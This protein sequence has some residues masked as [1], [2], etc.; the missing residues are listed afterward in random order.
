MEIEHLK[1]FHK[2]MDE[3]E[4][5]GLGFAEIHGRPDWFKVYYRTA[6][7]PPYKMEINL[8]RSCGHVES[9]GDYESNHGGSTA[10]GTMWD[11]SPDERYHSEMPYGL[12]C[13]LPAKMSKRFSQTVNDVPLWRYPLTLYRLI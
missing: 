1:I 4:Q 3:Y 8:S 9:G 7:Y 12:G 6:T 11:E 13:P 10:Y 5:L 2:W